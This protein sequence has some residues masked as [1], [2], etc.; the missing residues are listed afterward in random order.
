MKNK[1]HTIKE[2]LRA[3][4]IKLA[5]VDKPTRLETLAQDFQFI[6]EPPYSFSILRTIKSWI[7]KPKKIYAQPLVEK[8]YSVW[9]DNFSLACYD[10][11]DIHILELQGDAQERVSV[12]VSIRVQMKEL[13]INYKES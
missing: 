1:N 7:K 8:S 6:D 11:G 13:I 12:Y 5:N 4:R 2:Q 3:L 10:W 9:D